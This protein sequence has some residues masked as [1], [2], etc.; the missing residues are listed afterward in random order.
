MFYQIGVTE[1]V[2]TI[3][4]RGDL[5]GFVYDGTPDHCGPDALYLYN[6]V[7]DV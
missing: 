4:S 3:D 7:R 6:L 5:W 2:E 1:V